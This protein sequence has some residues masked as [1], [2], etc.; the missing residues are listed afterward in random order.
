MII[1]IVQIIL[2]CF[3]NFGNA[4][5]PE[6]TNVGWYWG[7]VNVNLTETTVPNI[8][9]GSTTD[10]PVQVNIAFNSGMDIY[11][12]LQDVI[13]SF[14][15]T[16]QKYTWRHDWQDRFT[17]RFGGNF[18]KN[19]FNIGGLTPNAFYIATTPMWLGV[20]W[21]QL[22][23]I[24]DYIK[25]NYFNIVPM[26]MYEEHYDVFLSE[27]DSFG[28]SIGFPKIPSNVDRVL[29]S[30]YWPDVVT[31][32]ITSQM[33]VNLH[34]NYVYPKMN[35]A[36]FIYVMP[37]YST[38]STYETASCHPPSGEDCV[39]QMV[40]YAGAYFEFLCT[41]HGCDTEGT[42]T[43]GSVQN[44]DCT[45]SV[46][47]L[48]GYRWNTDTNIV[49]YELGLEDLPPLRQY[50]QYFG[51]IACSLNSGVTVGMSMIV[52]T[53]SILFTMI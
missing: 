40:R 39:D 36:K 3:I 30:H 48:V 16:G 12:N 6:C 41:D 5:D 21:A 53:L 9:W 33:L 7:Y 32:T 42:W 24:T 29:I 8:I 45:G 14:N 38:T 26:I 37:L 4:D 31:T 10:D 28:N 18:P 1:V 13:F 15:V 25:N 44:T 11:W 17:Q 23:V 2:L 35:L 43:C 51:G 50:E 19:P 22:D 47:G 46:V 52:L 34:D 20:T 27:K 49:G